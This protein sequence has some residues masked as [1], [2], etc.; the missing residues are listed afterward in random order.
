MGLALHILLLIKKANSLSINII[1]LGYYEDLVQITSHTSNVN[2]SSSQRPDESIKTKRIRKKP[3]TKTDDFMGKLNLTNKSYN[4]DHG[5]SIYLTKFNSK[6]DNPRTSQNLLKIFHQNICGLRSKLDGLFNSLYPD[7]P[8]I[9]CITEHGELNS[10]VME[11]YI[12]GAS[13]CRQSA[14]RGGTCIFVLN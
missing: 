11:N 9:I 4:R 8:H 6:N 1:P 14:M 2:H 13:F 5:N 10:T 3:V 7:L 12:L